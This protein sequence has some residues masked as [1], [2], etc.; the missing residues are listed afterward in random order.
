[1]SFYP[2]EP[3]DR[4]QW[5]S[6]EY[7]RKPGTINRDSVKCGI[8]TSWEAVIRGHTHYKPPIVVRHLHDLRRVLKYLKYLIDALNADF[9]WRRLKS[10][11]PLLQW[12]HKKSY[13]EQLK[14]R[15]P[16]AT[17]LNWMHSYDGYIQP[18][19]C[20]RCMQEKLTFHLPG[21]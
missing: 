7:G 13:T 11:N 12:N 21:N 6:T 17:T 5:L 9:E 19:Y 2:I 8:G 4:I 18:T 10:V 3:L 14:T 1:M 15:G 16:W 20:K